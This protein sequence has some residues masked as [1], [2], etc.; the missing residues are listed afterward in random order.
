MMMQK[1]WVLTINSP[2]FLV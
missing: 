2:W 1:S